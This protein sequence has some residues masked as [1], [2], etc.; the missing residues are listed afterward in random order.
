M[1]FNG[2]V[3]SL[4]GKNAMTAKVSETVLR[5]CT[6]RPTAT[7]APLIGGHGDYV[8]ATGKFNNPPEK[9][10]E[11][12]F[13]GGGSAGAALY[14]FREPGIYAYVNHNLIEAVELG[15][16]AHFKIE[17]KWNDDLMQQI[18]PPGPIPPAKLGATDPVAVTR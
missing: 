10:L 6:R 15:A 18:T 9:D 1:V 12:W 16:A 13:V 5:S 8:G 14:T 17:G 2:R 7:P 4:T 11:T 3:G